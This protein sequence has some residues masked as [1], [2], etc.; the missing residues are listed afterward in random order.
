L[1]AVNATAADDDRP[2]ILDRITVT[3][4]TNVVIP[5]DRPFDSTIVEE[6]M[7]SLLMSFQAQGHLFSSVQIERVSQAD[8]RVEIA[9]RIVKGPLSTVGNI[10]LEGL[11]RTSPDLVRQHLD[12]NPGDTLSGDALE[13]LGH[14]A[15][16]LEFIDF[17]R[18]V[19]M[20]PAPGYGGVDLVL[21]FREKRP[22]RIEGGG[23]YSSGEK[24]GLV[25]SMKL[26]LTNVFG[27]GRDVMVQSQR[28]DPDR[29]ELLV[30]YRQPLLLF[31]RGEI[32]IETATRDYEEQFNDFSLA[33]AYR[34]RVASG[35]KLETGAAWSTITQ[36]GQLPSYS[37]YQLR[38]GIGRTALDDAHN[39][40]RGLTFNSSVTY[41]YRRYAQDTLAANSETALNETFLEFSGARYQ[42]LVADAGLHIS[43]G[44]AGLNSAEPLPPVAELVFLGGPPNLRGY[45]NQQFAALR[46]ATVTVEPYWRFS[47]GRVFAFADGAYLYNRVMVDSVVVGREAYELGYGLGMTLSDGQRQIRLSLGWNR[48]V[49]FNEPRLAIEFSSDL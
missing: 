17:L 46:A 27:G 3:G 21:Y 28:P 14:Q 9:A 16:E 22:F 11:E 7:A 45:R 4:D 13:R 1:L 34:T 32:E 19:M 8:G 41:R 26:D 18:P 48:A 40:F 31:G 35:L 12:L 33:A 47:S 43:L 49:A 38:F 36:A 30:R 2:V 25:W 29:S 15:D 20:T 37:R 10:N 23:G 39:P 24:G 42:P 6:A 5:I 44:Y